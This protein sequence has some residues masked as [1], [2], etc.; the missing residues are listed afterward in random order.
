MP[1]VYLGQ[2]GAEVLLPKIRSF[3]PLGYIPIPQTRQYEKKQMADGSWRYNVLAVH[4]KKWTYVLENLTAAELAPLQTEN[5]RGE[6]LHFQDGWEGPAWTWVFIAG[7]EPEIDLAI[8]TA[9]DVRWRLTLTL[10]E[11]PA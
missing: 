9:A 6:K 8:S 3:G 2:S 5:E 11:V 4:P 10:E 7:F 1:N